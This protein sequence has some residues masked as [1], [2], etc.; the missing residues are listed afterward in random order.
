MGE[1]QPGDV[2][3]GVAGVVLALVRQGAERAHG[4]RE[5]FGLAAGLVHPGGDRPEIDA[6][7]LR[8]AREGDEK[9]FGRH[10]EDPVG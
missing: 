1:H 4:Q 3:L 2:G 7:A 9:G 10:G 5:E 8:S 6:V